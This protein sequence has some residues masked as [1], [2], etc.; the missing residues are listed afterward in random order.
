MSRWRTVIGNAQ[1]MYLMVIMLDHGRFIGDRLIDIIII[2]QG[3]DS[4]CGLV[5]TGP[6]EIMRV[7]AEAKSTSAS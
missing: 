3:I 1:L 5:A 2:A 7:G 4:Y 6:P